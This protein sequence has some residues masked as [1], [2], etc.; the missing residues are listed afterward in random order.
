MNASLSQRVPSEAPK[1]PC[2]HC[3]WDVCLGFC[4]VLE[5]LDEGILRSPFSGSTALNSS[6]AQ[7][8][9]PLKLKL[10][11]E[12]NKYEYGMVESEGKE[13]EEPEG[14][15]E[16]DEVAD[17]FACRVEVEKASE[18]PAEPRAE[19]KRKREQKR[20][21]NINKGLD[22]LSELIFMVDP[23]LMEKAKKG[24]AEAAPKQKCQL[25]R[26]ELVNSAVYILARVYQ[27]NEVHKVVLAHL[28][29]GQVPGNMNGS[30][31]TPSEMVPPLP[32]HFILSSPWESPLLGKTDDAKE[33][34]TGSE[35]RSEKK[36]NREKKRRDDL[37][38]GMEK[39]EELIF[40]IDPQLK[41][42]AEERA[43]KR[44]VGIRTSK[45]DT[46][47]LSRVELVNNAVAALARIHQE[48]E[49]RKTILAQLASGMGGTCPVPSA[50]PR[51][52]P[53]ANAVLPSSRNLPGE[54][55]L[56]AA[57][58]RQPETSSVPYFGAKASPSVASFISVAA[59]SNVH[60]PGDTNLQA[61]M[62]GQNLPEVASARSQGGM[63][64]DADA[65][66][67]GPAMKKLKK[68]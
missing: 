12:E 25:G 60:M 34:E 64:L 36:R 27:D 21:G 46:Q 50:A 8:I 3:G 19:S 67:E 45:E 39:L 29:G 15:K 62:L 14:A 24:H 55:S 35:S 5:P 48:N 63:P 44:P 37:N 58:T 33:E 42:A 40:I 59:G 2:I 41:A 17:S 22:Q 1:K 61:S 52:I 57:T 10:S 30:D 47:L 65:Q 43:S 51:N 66:G 23:Q 68:C 31:G 38:K 28:A 18:S 53:Q 6:S 56:D 20:R 13:K 7:D 54:A 9:T 32:P 16:N 49:I 4:A 11:G 26:V